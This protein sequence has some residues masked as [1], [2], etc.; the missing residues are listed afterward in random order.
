MCRR[1]A[2][3]L[4]CLTESL[5][6]Q[7][8]FSKGQWFK[9][10]VPKEGM[11]KIDASFLK[12]LGVVP[13]SIDPSKVHIYGHPSGPLAQSL[14]V[15]YL[16]DVAEQATYLSADSDRSWEENEYILF[17]AADRHRYSFHESTQTFSYEPDPYVATSY[18]FLSIQDENARRVSSYTVPSGMPK[19]TLT[20]YQA[21]YVHE[22]E[23]H[24]FLHSGRVWYGESFNSR[25]ASLR[26]SLPF[27]PMSGAS[28]SVNWAAA[29][30]CKSTCALSLTYGQ[31]SV[32]TSL[33]FNLLSSGFYARRADHK[34][35]SATFTT[36]T[37]EDFICTFQSHHSSDV[38]YLDYLFVQAPT[39]LRYRR[40][41]PLFF[42]T[43]QASSGEVFAYE[44]EGSEPS[45]RLWEVGTFAAPQILS[46]TDQN[47]RIR[48]TY[49]GRT[50]HAPRFALFALEDTQQ[51]LFVSKVERQDLLRQTTP[52]FLIITHPLLQTHAKRLADFHTTYDVL[53]TLVTTTEKIY[54]QFS[55]GRPSPIAL[56]NYI[57]FL[58]HQSPHTLRYVLLFGAATFDY[59]NILNSSPTHVPGYLSIESLDP[60]LTYVSDD[61]FALLDQEEGLWEESAET[62]SILDIGIG[63][64]P[65]RSAEQ[66]K[67]I[68]DKMIS[69]A[70]ESAVGAWKQRITFVADDGDGNLHHRDSE[71]LIQQLNTDASLFRGERLYLDFFSQR[72][73]RK[74]QRSPAA[75]NRLLQLIEEGSLVV[76]FSGHG[77]TFFWTEEEIFTRSHIQDLKN[78]SRLPLFV[79]ATCDF[80][81]HDDP[82]LVSAGEELLF[83]PTGGAIALLTHARPVRSDS[84][85]KID[86]AFFK[87]L[88]KPLPSGEWPR[89]GDVIRNTKNGGNFGI[90]NRSFTLLGNPALQLAYPSLQVQIT[91]I[92]GVRFENFQGTLSAKSV[93]HFKGHISDLSEAPQLD[94]EG[95]LRIT[96]YDQSLPMR[97]L[98]DEGT[99]FTYQAYRS[100]LFQ[101]IVS[102]EHGQFAFAFPIPIDISY[103]KAPIRMYFYASPAS[104]SKEE[105]AGGL[106]SVHLGAPTTNIS[107]NTEGPSI[108]AYLNSQSFRDGERVGPRPILFVSLRDEQGIKLSETDLSKR[109]SFTL[110][111]GE[112]RQLSSFFWTEKDNYKTGNIVYPLEHLSDGTH[113]III[114]AWDN[115]NNFSSYTLNFFVSKHTKIKISSVTNYPNPANESITFSFAHDKGNH[116]LNVKLRVYEIEGRNIYN[117]SWRSFGNNGKIGNLRTN[118]PSQARAGV[119]AYQLLVEDEEEETQGMVVGKLIVKR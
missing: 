103:K 62:F 27:V 48:F 50:G 82:N 20:T 105:A 95:E 46:Y 104:P 4:F 70:T 55:S 2:V 115:L 32:G 76:N 114:Y 3:L 43:P 14:E 18:Y 34:M 69:Y 41:S 107:S 22:K 79:T 9:L 75:T 57:H 31:Q 68:V 47:Q 8:V 1:L 39:L 15:P 53:S 86:S 96:I 72:R 52:Q 77:S 94:Y 54:H 7:S 36:R 90:G 63:R 12:T 84:N 109:L 19:S 66:A 60:L 13:T 25:D 89:L 71:K 37:Q 112:N 67:V 111:Q 61:Y 117:K 116:L 16:S 65:A 119:Y 33:D 83:H 42:S 29:G 24:N 35:Q 100:L 26:L 92:N 28:V 113:R 45:L 23:R 73:E 110:D 80:G 91:E 49:T 59:K 93:A 56:R 38:A 21:Y 11:Y 118:F 106:S 30:A 64:L 40:G 10:S 88:H 78:Q 97:T 87:A 58:A 98:G 85:F 51:P 108:H 101:G 5:W 102:I 99:P 6:A 74:G 44:V 81:R 17:Y